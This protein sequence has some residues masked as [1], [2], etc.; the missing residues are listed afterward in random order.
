MRVVDGELDDRDAGL[1]CR[2]SRKFALRPLDMSALIDGL[3][4]G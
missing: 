3:M 1:S 2:R 4:S